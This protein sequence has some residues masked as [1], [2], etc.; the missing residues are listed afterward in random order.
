MNNRLKVK[1]LI[2]GNPGVGKSSI[3]MRL[4]DEEMRLDG[5]GSV[6]GLDCV[7]KEV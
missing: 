4:S 6:I 1:I 7:S 5:V 2:L 3:L